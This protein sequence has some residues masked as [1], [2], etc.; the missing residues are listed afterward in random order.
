MFLA[1]SLGSSA[2][3]MADIRK[4]P[5]T[6]V[7]AKSLRSNIFTPPPKTTG[8]SDDSFNIFIS[9]KLL[10]II[11]PLSSNPQSGFEIEGLRG[12]APK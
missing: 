3:E 2:C 6:P 1:A 10:V 8:I 11:S 9:S 4:N 12:P 5:S 7:S